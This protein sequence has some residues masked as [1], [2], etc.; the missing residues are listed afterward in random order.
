[1]N[2]NYFSC[3][4]KDEVIDDLLSNGYS[5]LKPTGTNALFI[6]KKNKVFWKCGRSHTKICSPYERNSVTLK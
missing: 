6:N 5:E 4:I 2:S 1:M 3:E